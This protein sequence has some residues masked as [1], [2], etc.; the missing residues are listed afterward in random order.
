MLAD[1]EIVKYY[2]EGFKVKDISTMDGRTV[3]TIYRILKN[4]I[5]IKDC[6]ILDSEI[7]NKAILLYKEGKSSREVA[8]ELNISPSSV[9]RIA[10][11]V[12]ITRNGLEAFGIKVEDLEK[13]IEKYEN[14]MGAERACADYNFSEKVLYSELKRRGMK[15][16]GYSEANAISATNKQKRGLKG[17][18]VLAKDCI[19]FESFYELLF[20]IQCLKDENIT[21]ISRYNGIVKYVDNVGKIRHYNPDFIIKYGGKECII[22]VKPISRIYEEDV[23]DKAKYAINFFKCY[24]IVTEDDLILY[25]AETLSK[26]NISTKEDLNKY[27]NRYKNKI[28]NEL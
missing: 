9:K 11:K 6:R 7:L 21:S 17:E 13:A 5:K 24:R 8:K 28:K 16:R 18:V 1:S 19:K 26:Y 15:V 23:K 14:G 22:E 10:K 4:Y 25:S 2:T 12:G 3:S 27:I 20:I